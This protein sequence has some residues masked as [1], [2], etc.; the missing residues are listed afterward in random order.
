MV[1]CKTPVFSPSPPF[2][3]LF[4]LSSLLTFEGGIHLGQARFKH[5]AD[6]ATGILES[7]RTSISDSTSLSSDSSLSPNV[8]HSIRPIQDVLSQLQWDSRITQSKVEIVYS[9]D[10]AWKTT[11]LSTFLETG[12]GPG[13]VI[14]VLYDK[15]NVWDKERR[16]DSL[17]SSSQ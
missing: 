15:V 6:C 5:I 3:S 13:S 7:Y 17:N 14:S 1:W 4:S 12:V 9:I 2:V 10:S 8:S 11:S 16:I